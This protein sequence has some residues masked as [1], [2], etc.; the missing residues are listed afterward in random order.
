MQLQLVKDLAELMRQYGLGR[1][2]VRDGETHVL[3]EAQKQAVSEPVVVAAPVTAAV[4][5]A[6]KAEKPAE[7]ASVPETPK[8]DAYCQKSPLVGTLYL[9]PSEDGPRFVEVG[10]KV[11]KGDTLCIVEAMKV[12]NELTAEID[13]VIT[14]VCGKN[15]ALVEFGQPLFLIEKI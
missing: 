12:L 7:S 15:A 10:S 9:A 5:T 2:E 13:G 1:L 6:V 14:E 8:T 4:Q 11:K 3:L